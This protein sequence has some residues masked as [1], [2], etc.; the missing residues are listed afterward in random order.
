MR[1]QSLRCMGRLVK[2]KGRASEKEEVLNQTKA[3]RSTR[4]RRK[5]EGYKNFGGKRRWV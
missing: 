2:R 3:V 5:G 1:R 4:V